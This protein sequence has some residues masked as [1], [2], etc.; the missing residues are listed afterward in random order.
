MRERT[1]RPKRE[2]PAPPPSIP[3]SLFL[4]DNNSN[5]WGW[6]VTQAPETDDVR[7]L[8]G[9]LQPRR[10][11]SA[12]CTSETE[13]RT[14][15]NAGVGEGGIDEERQRE[16]GGSGRWCGGG[17]PRQRGGGHDGGLAV[18]REDVS[19][20]EPR[21]WQSLLNT[22]P[23]DPGSLGGWGGDEGGGGLWWL[24]LSCIKY[25]A[26]VGDVWFH[27]S[28]VAYSL[29]SWLFPLRPF[30]PGKGEK[31]TGQLAF[32]FLTFDLGI[33]T[34]TATRTAFI[35]TYFHSLWCHGVFCATPAVWTES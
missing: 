17:M 23:R 3:L 7:T 9:C 29:A 22:N 31:V 5:L 15:G 34:H 4:L 26:S 20:L 28:E 1:I 32:S 10:H 14:Q 35:F 8:I 25:L 16:R 27:C 13:C 6:P 12:D 19:L 33:V 30:L 18:E 24:Q 2:D 21:G 11:P